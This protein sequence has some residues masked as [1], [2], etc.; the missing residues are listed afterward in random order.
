MGTPKLRFNNQ[1]ATS[2]VTPKVDQNNQYAK[3]TRTTKA[4]QQP[5]FVRVS[6]DDVDDPARLV[7]AINDLQKNQAASSLPSRTDPESEGVYFKNLKITSGISFTLPHGLGRPYVGFYC[8]RAY[9]GSGAPSFVED[10]LPPGL[11]PD[12][13]IQIKPGSS[14]DFDIKIF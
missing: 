4:L 9:P 1:R 10:N 12:K 6:E 8:T 11:T 7:R 2:V 14:G 13:A 5:G 3:P